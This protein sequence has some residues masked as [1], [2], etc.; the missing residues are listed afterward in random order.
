MPAADT[1]RSNVAASSV[2]RQRRVDNST[3]EIHVGN[4]NEMF[5]TA[6]HGTGENHDGSVLINMRVVNQTLWMVVGAGTH[7]SYV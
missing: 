6:V 1:Y 2:D 5:R 3:C 4:N 7:F